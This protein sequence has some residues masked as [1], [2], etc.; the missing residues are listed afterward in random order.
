MISF[1]QHGDFKNTERFFKRAPN[2]DYRKILDFYGKAGVRALEKATPADTGLTASSWEYSYT[3]EKGR[4][5][6]SWNNT[7]IEDGAPIAILIQY[8]HGTRNGGYVQGRDYINPA[9]KPI[10]D[11]LAEQAWKEITNL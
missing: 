9:L 2:V 4:F 3:I 11:S 10:F 1:R 8:G 5:S 6:V 7:N